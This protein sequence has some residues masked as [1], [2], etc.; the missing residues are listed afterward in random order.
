MGQKGV[1]IAYNRGF[2]SVHISRGRME[3]QRVRGQEGGHVR[4][5]LP[6]NTTHVRGRRVGGT[7]LELTLADLPYPARSPPPSLRTPPPPSP[8][9]GERGCIITPAAHQ[10]EGQGG[11]GL[12]S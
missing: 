11:E 6:L 5:D 2:P 9:Q 4:K 3:V 12:L 1:R 8:L 7:E 10:R